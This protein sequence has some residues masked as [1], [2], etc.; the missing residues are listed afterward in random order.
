MAGSAADSQERRE[1]EPGEEGSLGTRSRPRGGPG[2]TGRPRW[3][4]S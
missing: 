4:Y 1:Q 2:A 3:M